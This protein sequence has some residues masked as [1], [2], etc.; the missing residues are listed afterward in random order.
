M[1]CKL[2]IQ[3]DCACDAE[4][5][6]VK[7]LWLV[8]H[9]E[10]EHNVSSNFQFDPPLTKEGWAQAARASE[11]VKDLA[12]DLV[13]VS[14][15]R[16]TLQTADVMFGG[17]PS[18]ACEDLRE[19][20]F[21]SCNFRRD[22]AEARAEFADVDFSNID[23]GPDPQIGNE[24]EDERGVRIRAQSFLEWLRARPEQQIAVVTHWQMLSHG[25]MPCL[26]PKS[27]MAERNFENCNIKLITW[28]A[29]DEEDSDD[30][31]RRGGDADSAIF[32]V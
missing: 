7:H 13:C 31:M 11:E 20:L 6:G 27:E 1:G 14:P 16:R 26:R 18:I 32:P 4:G 22:V 12:L 28:A 19:R 10:A 30:D 8:R 25:L 23:E 3:Q 17:F 21:C 24:S 9:A 29:R 2:S 15:L 5:Q